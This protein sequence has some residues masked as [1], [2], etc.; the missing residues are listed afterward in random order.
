MTNNCR[1]LPVVVAAILISLANLT[2]RAADTTPS[3]RLTAGPHLLLD[4]TLVQDAR[5]I[6]REVNRPR[7]TLPG[8]VVTGKE[9]RNFQPYMT[10]VRDPQTRRFRIWYDAS[11][12]ESQMHLAHMESLDGEHWIR[13]HRELP[14]PPGMQ[15]RFGAAII[16]RG[17]E[18]PDRSARYTFGSWQNGGLIIAVSPDG[19]DWRMLSP[20]VVLPHDHDI[21]SVHWDPIRKHYI[22]LVS[23]YTTGPTWS[24]RRRATMMSTSSDLVHW[25]KPWFV[26]TPDDTKDEGETQF[27]CM[28]GVIARGGLLIG[29]LK[30]LRDDLPADPG[31]PKQGIGYTVLAWSRDGRTWTRD[32]EPFLDRAPEKGAWDHAMSWIDC[33]LPV[34]DEVYFYY[35]GYARGHKVERFTERQI[36]LVKI[37]RDRY[38]ARAAGDTPGTFRTPLAA[39][40][41]K[42]LTLNV[43]APRGE[44]RAQLL[45]A[46]GRPVPGYTF[47]DCRP[48]SGDSLDAP[49]KWKKPLAALKGK[50]VRLEFSLK[51]AKLYAFALS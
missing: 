9:D 8:P 40:D 34:E 42:G 41:A 23:T 13:P 47:A 18:F 43:D 35:G 7:R 24:G 38:V 21:N 17:V 31:G 37:R 30:V 44:V 2:V 12:N 27:Y 26:L 45:D 11:V 33:Q 36:G 14:D 39:L 29:T 51:N 20:G 49:V 3:L 25:E 15:L 6:T 10:V 32:R 22:A 50:P 28:S 16:D 48:V 46:N 19:L 5:G 1:W 4:D